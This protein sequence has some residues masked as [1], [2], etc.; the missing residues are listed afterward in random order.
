MAVPINFKGEKGNASVAI[1]DS[2]AK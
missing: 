1:A 2:Y